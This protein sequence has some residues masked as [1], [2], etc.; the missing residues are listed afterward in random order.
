M[1]YPSRDFFV[2]LCS[3]RANISQSASWRFIGD[4][5]NQR[6]QPGKTVIDEVAADSSDNQRGAC[7]PGLRQ[8]PEGRGGFLYGP[9]P[10]S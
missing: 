9:L 6:P 7:A 1:F 10:L 4:Y 5:N 8:P 3:L 2:F